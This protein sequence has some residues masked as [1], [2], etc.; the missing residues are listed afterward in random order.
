MAYKAEKY[1]HH[2]R[3]I[4]P[5][6]WWIVGHQQSPLV[7]LQSKVMLISITDSILIMFKT[8]GFICSL[9]VSTGLPC[10]P[11]SHWN[12][13]LFLLPLSS[14]CGSMKYFQRFLFLLEGKVM[15]IFKV[16]LNS[17]FLG[18]LSFVMLTQ[19]CN[20]DP[21]LLHIIR[22]SILSICECSRH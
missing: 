15:V 4:P 9:G 6:A 21:C 11:K 1:N 8:L 20:K 19:V 13:P 22:L 17:G 10:P 12:S 5:I 7:R 18:K 2:L 3:P 16:S 14:S